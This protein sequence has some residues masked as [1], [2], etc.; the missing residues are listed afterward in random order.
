MSGHIHASR[1]EARDCEKITLLEKAGEYLE[2]KTQVS[3]PL[4]A[5][6]PGGKVKVCTHI[7]DKLVTRRDGTKEVIETKGFSTDTW[8]LKKKM[9]EANYPGIIYTVWRGGKK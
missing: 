3:F 9:F 4:Y 8:A 2:V 1:Q 7:V 5:D 6:S